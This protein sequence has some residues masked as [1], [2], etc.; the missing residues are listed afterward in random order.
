M[1]NANAISIDQ[2]PNFDEENGLLQPEEEGE[3]IDVE[4]EMVEDECVFLKGYGR[5]NLSDLSP[6]KIVKNPDGSLSQAAMMQG[7]LSKERREI[8]IMQ[9]EAK[10]AEEAAEELNNG[11]IT[12]SDDPFATRGDPNNQFASVNRGYQLSEWK[13]SILTGSKGSYGKKTN[14]TMIEQREGLPIFKLREELIKVLIYGLRDQDVVF[15][16]IFYLKTVFSSYKTARISVHIRPLF[17]WVERL[18]F[19]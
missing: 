10:L 9:Q 7:A 12:R 5:R 17:I 6:V 8:K 19:Y 3:D 11:E 1:R 4:I 13:K 14:K 16:M 2:L 15:F 18:R